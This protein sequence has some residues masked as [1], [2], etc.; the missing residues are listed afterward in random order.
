MLLNAAYTCCAKAAGMGGCTKAQKVAFDG[1][2][3]CIGEAGGKGVDG[4]AAK[5][6]EALGFTMAIDQLAKGGAHQALADMAHDAISRVTNA[7]ACTMGKARHSKETMEHLT[8]AHGFLCAAGA[9]CDV[10]KDGGDDMV[11]MAA[12]VGD[13]GKTE[14]TRAAELAKALEVAQAEKAT[15]AKTLSDIVPLLDRLSKRVEDIAQTP[16]P[17]M[18]ARVG[19]TSVSKTDDGRGD[20]ARELTTEEIAAAIAKMSPN[21]V[22]LIPFKAARFR[23]LQLNGLRSSSEIREVIT[24]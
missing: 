21:E 8:K 14:G 9:S 23:P 3:E 11:D 20:D 4:M 17:P 12:G 7:A 18:V 16:L 2:K 13:L 22:E 1:A 5:S 10:A 15:L 24:R 19:M 6:S